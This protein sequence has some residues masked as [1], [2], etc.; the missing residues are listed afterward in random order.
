M[1]A[2]ILGMWFLVGQVDMVPAAEVWPQWRGPTGDSVSPVAELPTRWSKT[3]NVVWKTDLPGWGNSTP[4]IWKDAI[5]VTSQDDESLVLLRIDRRSGKIVWKKEVGRGTPRRKGAVGNGRYHDE[6]NM[7]SPSPVT[8]GKHVWAHFGTG[9][10]ACYDFDGKQIWRVDMTKRYGPYSIWWGHANSPVL[11]GD[12]LISQCAQDPLGGGQNYV[13]A[14][15]KLTGEEKWLVKRVTGAEKEPADSYTTPLVYRHEG[16]AELIVFGGNVLD[17]YDPATGKRLWY[18]DVFKGNRVI[19]GPTLAGDTVYAVQG[20]K[21]PLFAIRAGGS[22]DVTASNVLWQFKK[23]DNPDAASPAVAKGLVFL[24][25]NS[26]Q[27]ICIDAVTGKELW[28]K[29]L[30][31]QFRATP[32]VAGNRIYFFGK[33]GNTSIVEA[34]GEFKKVSEC[35]LDEDTVASPAVAGGDLFIRTKGH[36]YRIGDKKAAGR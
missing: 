6:N 25:T 17:A 29:R 35:D 1:H 9:D 12:L 28:N 22:G 5:F 2:L 18:C 33:D 7:A 24:A 20:M 27:G 11:I 4:A 36:L 13:V 23:G 3:E 34:A 26:G 32:L 8:D 21:G 30:A 31:S 16:R 15:N 14:L 10:L 19:S